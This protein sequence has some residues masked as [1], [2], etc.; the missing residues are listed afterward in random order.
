MNKISLDVLFSSLFAVLAVLFNFWLI[1]EA[2]FYLS[3]A[4]LGT[5]MLI[6]RLAPTFSNLS[7]LGSSQALIR[8]TSLNKDDVEKIKCYFFISIVL[9]L[10]S[11][12]FLLIL[13]TSFSEAIETLLLPDVADRNSYL[14]LTFV[15]ISI[16]HLSY[17]IL[18][19]FLNLRKILMYNII[20]MM[21]ASLVML[22]V[23]LM[24]A[25]SENLI[26]VLTL[27]LIIMAI[28]QLL[29]LGYIILQLNLYRFPSKKMLQSESRSFFKYG[30]PRA[31]MTF[32]EMFMLT[33]GSLLV[34]KD[35]QLVGS[36]LIA[37]TLA[38][39]VLIILQPISLLS[40]VIVG[41]NTDSDK[42]KKTLNLL[43]GGV[44]YSSVLVIVILY[45]WIDVL[46]R[47]WLTKEDTI[48]DAVSVFKILVFGLVPYCIF[49][50]L[51]GY[52][53]IRFYKPLNL[54]SIAIATL[55]HVLL[56][57]VFNQFC[58]TLIS[59]SV[60][61]M[62]AF[63]IMGLWSFSWCRKEIYKQTYFKFVYFLIISLILFGINYF[64]NFY[65]PN[66][67]GLVAALFLTAAGFLGFF[68]FGRIVFVKDVLSTFEFKFLDRFVR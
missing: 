42:P 47:F 23:F 38:R 8:F 16:L 22:A 50:G 1:K 10:A 58:E 48:I 5:F 49:Q 20:N 35:H 31:A 14:A 3:A 4:L 59:L 67:I 19:Y 37:I 26:E 17:L 30:L 45:N 60:S 63:V 7:Q 40:S 28:I 64:I 61:L 55:V 36:F 46:I 32:L 34:K 21:N 43:F 24:V 51:K 65:F 53:E 54:F 41:H 56:F 29:I 33:I 52:I 27:S 66:L 11:S 15:Y 44:I 57:F 13:F 39:I 62:L 6:R 18:P 68:I 12:L 9:W 25:N 2:E